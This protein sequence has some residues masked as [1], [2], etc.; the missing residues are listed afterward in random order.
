MYPLLFEIGGQPVYSY[1]V[2]LSLA[3]LAAL[4]LVVQRSVSTGIDPV[5]TMDLAIYTMVAAAIGGKFSVFFQDLRYFMESPESLSV[6]VRSRGDFYGATLAGFATTWWFAGRLGMSRWKIADLFAPAVALTIAVGRL[7]CLLAGCDYGRRTD[8]PWAVT[9]TDPVAAM[10]NGTPLEVPLHPVQIYEAAAAFGIFLV[11]LATERRG[12][13]AGR[14]FWLLVLLYAVSR[15]VTELYRGDPRGM[16]LGLSTPQFASVVLAP[17]SI[18]M[19]WRLRVRS[20][21]AAAV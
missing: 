19:L 5:R 11:L 10:T 18:V 6:L 15:F 1:G 21:A 16:I 14:S 17:M 3:Y 20:A 7:A 8:L 12:I 4:Y 2:L 9:F 13:A